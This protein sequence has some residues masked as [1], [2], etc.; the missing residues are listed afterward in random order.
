[1]IDFGSPVAGIQQSQ[2]SLSRTAGR[3]AKAGF[4]EGD[5]VDPGEEAVGLID[6]RLAV[7]ANVS[8]IQTQDEVSKSLLDLLG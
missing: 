2:Q 4:Q 7:Q 8:V 1:M 6:A 5:T 3:L